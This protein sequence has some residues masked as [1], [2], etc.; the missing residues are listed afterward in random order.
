MMNWEVSSLS[1]EC[2]YDE[3]A[4]QSHCFEVFIFFNFDKDIIYSII[5]VISSL[6]FYYESRPGARQHDVI[7]KSWYHSL[8]YFWSSAPELRSRYTASCSHVSQESDQH[9]PFVEDWH[10]LV[11]RQC[12]RILMLIMHSSSPPSCKKRD[13]CSCSGL[14]HGPCP[15][16]RTIVQQQILAT[17][18]RPFLS[19][20]VSWIRF[21]ASGK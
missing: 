13:M 3:D 10:A 12:A 17:C 21:D 16:S 4:Q 2:E 5:L 14:P 9:N 7:F 1:W 15:P 6:C 19:P 11:V 8:L 18:A 20:Q